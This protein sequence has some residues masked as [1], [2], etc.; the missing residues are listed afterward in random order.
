MP[1]QLLAVWVF[2]FSACIGSFLNVCI[3]RLP[4]SESIV[5]PG[6]RCTFCGSRIRPYDNI[7]LISYLLLA[8]RCR[9]CR[10]PISARYFWVEAIT[11]SIGLAL[12]W[13]F[14]F[15]VSALIY[16]AFLCSLTVAS[17]IDVDLRIIPD[18][19]SL[20]GLLIGLLLSFWG[21]PL[22]IWESFSGALTGFCFLFFIAILYSWVTGREGLGGGDIKLIA[23]IGAFLGVNGVFI[24]ILSASLLGVLVGGATIVFWKKSFRMQ[25]P[26]GPFLSVGALFSLLCGER[27]FF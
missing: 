11:T 24:A 20:G 5:Y 25:I 17:F 23:M 27:L 15:S 14:G 13:K 7:P 3:Y 10:I 1:E 21:H 2:I 12:F 8:G 18:S 6:S 22:T 16:F 19:I 9:N 4:R 26:F